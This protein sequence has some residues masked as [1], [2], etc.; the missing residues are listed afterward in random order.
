MLV[1]MSGLQPTAVLFGI[2]GSKAGDW[3]EWQLVI[4]C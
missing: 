4:T 3:L 1:I 2:E